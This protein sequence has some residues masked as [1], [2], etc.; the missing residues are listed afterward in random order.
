[1]S[2]ESAGGRPFR[3]VQ[4]AAYARP[5]DDRDGRRLFGDEFGF[6]GL[7]LLTLIFCLEVR[8]R[9]RENISQCSYTVIERQRL[10]VTSGLS[11]VGI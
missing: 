10:V 4:V 9:V 2:I 6:L 7:V 1:M 3:A 11:R 8:F 5:I